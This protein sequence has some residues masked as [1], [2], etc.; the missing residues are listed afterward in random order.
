MNHSP[1]PSIPSPFHS[2]LNNTCKHKKKESIQRR[3]FFWLFDLPII[4][5]MDD[6][7]KLLDHLMGPN[8]DGERRQ[9]EVD[10]FVLFIR[11][12]A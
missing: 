4:L 3:A 9:G 1:T 8:R 10:V 12:S 11:D 5:K 7:R 2:E 6:I